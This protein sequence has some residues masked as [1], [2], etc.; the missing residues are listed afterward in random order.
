MIF[1]SIFFLPSSGAAPLLGR[2]NIELT[3]LSQIDVFLMSFS[4]PNEAC[5][6]QQL[7]LEKLMEQRLRR[8]IK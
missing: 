7:I 4:V 1:N 6:L 2:K 3:I 5:E 8:S